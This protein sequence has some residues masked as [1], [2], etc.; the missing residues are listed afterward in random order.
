MRIG[1]VN[2]GVDLDTV[3]KLLD[4]SKLTEE[5]CRNCWVFS[6]CDL[7]QCY[8][9]GITQLSSCNKHKYC[10]ESRD[11]YYNTLRGCLFIS[12]AMEY[13]HIGG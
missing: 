13:K 2:S 3:I 10:V 9:D 7:C 6:H 11:S 5:Q 8:S 1:N 4:V 12:E